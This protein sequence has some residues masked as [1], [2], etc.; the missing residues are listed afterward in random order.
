MKTA[1][2]TIDDYL[3]AL[4]PDKR[5]ALEKLRKAIKAVVP[6]AE[7]G[8][9][10]QVPTFRLDGRPLVHFGAAKD[11]CA[12]YPGAY[13]IAACAAELARYDTSKGTIR[14]DPKKPLPAALVR[15]LVKARLE[16]RAEAAARRSTPGPRGAGR[17]PRTVIR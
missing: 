3:A 11:H 4:T 9:S 7:E 17:P 12:F 8:I 1:P 2:E 10:Y 16:Q 14:F 6:H 5:A 15:K 13:P